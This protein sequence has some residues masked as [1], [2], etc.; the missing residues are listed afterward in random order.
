MDWTWLSAHL[1]DGT[2]IQGVQLRF[3]EL[4]AMAFGYEQRAGAVTEIAGLDVDYAIAGD[5]LVRATSA[6][7]TPTGTQLKFEP[8]AF[9]ALRIEAP[10]G[11]V[12][13]FPRAMARVRTA[14]GR[15]GLGWIE[16]GHN[17]PSG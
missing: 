8:I 14:D 13:E 15:A 3:P 1:D 10:D 16:W 12:C 7:I 2:R 11:R 17:L 6:A 9:G 5:R 4:P